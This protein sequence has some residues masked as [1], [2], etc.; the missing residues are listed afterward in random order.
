MKRSIFTKGFADG[1][2]KIE[3]QGIHHLKKRTAD[4]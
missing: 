1:R 4:N 3:V 2:K